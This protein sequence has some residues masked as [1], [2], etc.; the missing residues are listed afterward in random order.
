MFSSL[1]YLP[2]FRWVSPMAGVPPEEKDLQ[3]FYNFNYLGNLT[4]NE[5]NY[6]NIT[7][8]RHN[9]PNGNIKRH[10]GICMTTETN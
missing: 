9:I 5:G 1:D 10:F 7:I 2:P 3:Q 6:I 8:Q 4:Y